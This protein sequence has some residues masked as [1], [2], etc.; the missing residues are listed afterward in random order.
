[1]FL[2]SYHIKEQTIM[3][4]RATQRDSRLIPMKQ[5]TSN[6]RPNAR[7]SCYG[8]SCVEQFILTKHKSVPVKVVCAGLRHNVDRAASGAARLRRDTVIDDL[9]LPH[10]FRR[11]CNACCTCG[12]VSV[13]ESVDCDG[14]AAR[15]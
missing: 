6:A 3:L 7:L 5:R 1:M 15:T 12:F 14:I 10:N 2:F 8:F 13:V 11:Q 4:N 9:K